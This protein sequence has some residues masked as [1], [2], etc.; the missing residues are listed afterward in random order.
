T[1]RSASS[2]AGWYACPVVSA[3][4]LAGTAATASTATVSSAG[5]ASST[6]SSSRLPAQRG[7]TSWNVPGAGIAAEA[8]VAALGSPA[9]AA[10]G[11]PGERGRGGR[12]LAARVGA[13]GHHSGGVQLGGQPG[14]GPAP[15]LRRVAIGLDRVRVGHAVGR[16]LG[17]RAWP[18]HRGGQATRRG[19]GQ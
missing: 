17:R 2:R 1:R 18:E 14:Q 12:A 9:T 8:P 5:E 6:L 13:R 7:R 11:G 3:G 10:R 19:P 16:Q 4:A 15:G